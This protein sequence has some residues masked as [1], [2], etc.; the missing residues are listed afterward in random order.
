M[1]L[2]SI[3]KTESLN[4]TNVLTKSFFFDFYFNQV[5]VKFIDGL[6]SIALYP[7]FRFQSF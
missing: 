7:Y 4:P 1:H 5:S 2:K 6:Y 3:E